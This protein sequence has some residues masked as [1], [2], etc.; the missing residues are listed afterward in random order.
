MAGVW[1]VAAHCCGGAAILPEAMKPA[2]LAKLSRAALPVPNKDSRARM[3]AATF[4]SIT[5]IEPVRLL[6]TANIRPAL[7]FLFQFQNYWT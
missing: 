1:S 6:R 3:P 5:R 2:S 7:C 4:A